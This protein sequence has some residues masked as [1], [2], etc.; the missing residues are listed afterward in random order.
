MMGSSSLPLIW[1]PLPTC[2]LTPNSNYNPIVPPFSPL[3]HGILCPEFS[4]EF[5]QSKI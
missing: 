2:I 4:L 5:A 1:T 3:P